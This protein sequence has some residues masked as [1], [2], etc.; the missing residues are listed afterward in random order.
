MRS[1]SSPPKPRNLSHMDMVD[2]F[3]SRTFLAQFDLVKILLRTET[4]SSLLYHHSILHFYNKCTH[5]CFKILRLQKKIELLIQCPMQ[6]ILSS[7]QIHAERLSSK[8]GIIVGNI[9][10]GAKAFKIRS[11]CRAALVEK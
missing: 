5:L 1:F 11:G 4:M 3:M 8:E 10:W 2:I 7:H 9:N 6:H